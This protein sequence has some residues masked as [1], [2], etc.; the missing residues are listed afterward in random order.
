MRLIRIMR[1][2]AEILQEAWLVA[3]V[4][5]NDRICGALRI[6]PDWFI[7]GAQG[8]GFQHYLEDYPARGRI[9]LQKDWSYH[10]ASG[11]WRF[12][13]SNS[14]FASGCL[15]VRRGRREDGIIVFLP[16]YQDGAED[17]LRREN[18]PQNMKE[19]AGKLGMGIA[20]WDW[21]LQGRRLDGC[22]YRGLRSVY[23]AER[24]YSRILPALGTSLWREGVAEL[25]FAL[26]QIRRHVGPG[27]AIHVV[28][29]SMGG[30]F[31]YLAPLLGTD[32]A[33]TIA[34]GS[35][36]RVKDLMAEGK[37]RLHGYFF[38]PLNGLAY[39]DLDDV[40]AEVLSLKH[41]LH[42]IHG[43]RDAGCLESTRRVLADRA[44]EEG[45]SLWIDVLPGHGHVFS[46]T[47]MR[48]IIEFLSGYA[49]KVSCTAPAETSSPK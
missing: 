30:C 10:R 25:Q 22:L 31:A 24:E 39:F 9:V 17:V 28:G 42:I 15:R 40:V 16:G 2:A 41:P 7:R 18:H 38:Y 3:R 47:I 45:R 13:Y 8:G 44:A 21:P 46:S 33:T 32:I 23:S 48:R 36:A 34:A 37:T 5:A 49:S 14:L 19:V 12:G 27:R 6:V 20:C 11:E 35:C 29:W 26:Q 4:P 1:R 43:E